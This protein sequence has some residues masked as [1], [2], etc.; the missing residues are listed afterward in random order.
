MNRTFNTDGYCDPEINYMVDLSDRLA[1]IK[2]MVDSEKYFT[3]NRARQY[4][5]TTIL[6]ALAD[7]LKND[8]EVVSLDFQTLST[9]S[10]ES[11]ESFVASFAEELLDNVQQFPDDIKV[12]LSAFAERRASINSLQ[13]LFKTLKSWCAKSEK[14][15]VLIID[16]VDTAANNQVFLDFL[17]Q[18][19]AYYLKRRRTPTFQSVILA[20]VYDIRNIKRKIH[21]GDEHKQNSPWITREGNEE[22]ESSLSFDD[23][24][25]DHKGLVPYDIAADFRID[26]SFSQSDIAGMLQDYES[27]HHTGMDANLISS[28]LYDYTS[29]YPYLVSRMCKLM[30]ERIVGTSMYTD[31]SRVWTREGFMTALK[32][33][34]EDNNPLFESLMGKLNDFP[35]LNRVI[36]RLLFQGQSIAYNADDIAVQNALMFGFVK[37]VNSTVMLANRIF[38]MRLYSKFLLDY[39]EQNSSIYNEG[40]RQKNQFI[41]DGHLNVRLVLEKFVETFDYLYGDRTE[42]F[43]EDEGRKYFM[44]FLRPIIN[45]TGNCYVEAQTRNR[46]RMDLVIDYLGEQHII[47]MKVWHGNAYN[48]RG[49]QQLSDYLDYFHLKKGYMLSFNF[50]KKKE[51]GVK[52]I[53][54]GDRTIV[55][56][57]V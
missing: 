25:R 37:I 13:M 45:G 50:N 43:L 7:Y 47:E 38:E 56:A 17:S 54:I 23:C 34:L 53:V 44:L 9:L 24:P 35:E 20:G 30:D 12:K 48:E 22:N 8:Y 33:L 40:A 6:T 28:L 57:V 55:E 52:D 2:A 36:S 11:E 49:R 39:K 10:F 51:I 5:K 42:S 31:L 26:M 41:I 16:E 15:I 4:G 21:P 14:R 19:R 27:D 29:G 3:I 46:E 1:R 32:M 18:L